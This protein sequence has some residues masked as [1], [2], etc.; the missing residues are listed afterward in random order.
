MRAAS[1]HSAEQLWEHMEVDRRMSLM[2]KELLFWCR[3]RSGVGDG[4]GNGKHVGWFL[5][6]MKQAS[7]VEMASTLRQQEQIALIPHVQ[8][9]HVDR[10]NSATV[11]TFTPWKLAGA[12]NQGSLLPTRE[13]HSAFART[14]RECMWKEV[15]LISLFIGK[16]FHF[17]FHHENQ[18]RVFVF[19]Y[20]FSS[21]NQF[22]YKHSL[23]V[24][25]IQEVSYQL[26]LMVFWR[27]QKK[28][29]K[30]WGRKETHRCLRDC[31]S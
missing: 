20:F 15:P 21:L 16:D 13:D 30:N 6:A 8:W 12:A 18:G 5:V 11:G 23:W 27:Q 14:S 10:W 4:Q 3:C 24:V 22:I 28:K 25:E 9:H 19:T 7:G 29:Q 31:F 17:E 1:G 26:S 2:L